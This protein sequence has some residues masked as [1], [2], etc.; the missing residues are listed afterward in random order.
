[1]FLYSKIIKFAQPATYRVNIT[2]IIFL[3][4]NN[5]EN[6]L[7]SQNENAL[8]SS[9]FNCYVILLLLPNIKDVGNFRRNLVL[10]NPKGK[11]RWKS[12]FIFLAN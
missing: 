2:L 12:T 4:K 6:T 9:A 5:L 1:M 11:P 10:A 8:V 7:F 3:I